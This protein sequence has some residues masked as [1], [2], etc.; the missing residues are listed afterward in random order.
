MSA[1]LERDWLDGALTAG[2]SGVRRAGALD[3]QHVR[4]ALGHVGAV[5][6]AM[7]DDDHLALLDPLVAVA[8]MH[9][10]P[11]LDDEEELVLL[12]VVVPHERA[13]NLDE[14]DLEVVDLA[15]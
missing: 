10:K 6:D 8:E 1:P 3:Q 9:Q 7:R 12:L 15:R 13:L 5:L 14:L 4:L 2:A 11:A